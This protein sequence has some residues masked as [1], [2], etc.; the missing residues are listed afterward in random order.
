MFQATQ[1]ADL[2][3]TMTK[4]HADQPGS[5]PLTVQNRGIAGTQY[6]T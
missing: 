6:T 2:R 3:H 5:A 1:Q 4:L